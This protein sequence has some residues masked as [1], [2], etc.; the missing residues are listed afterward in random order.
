MKNEHGLF[1]A[2]VLAAAIITGSTLGMMGNVKYVLTHQPKTED[3]LLL[4]SGPKVTP[5]IS[6]NQGVQT[7]SASAAETAT[8]EQTVLISPEEKTEV[9]AMLNMVDTSSL[10]YNQRIKTFQE[11]HALS[12]TGVLDSTTLGLLIQ[13]AQLQ[14]AGQRLGN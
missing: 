7:P 3:K 4:A 14:K 11:K 9:V 5:E 12:V 13:Q 8:R 1:F 10:N 6:P 2:L